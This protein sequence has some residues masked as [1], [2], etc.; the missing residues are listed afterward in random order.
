MGFSTTTTTPPTLDLAL[1]FKVVD[2]DG[3]YTAVQTIDI[4]YGLPAPLV[5]LVGINSFET[6]GLP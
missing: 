6:V 1:G 4:E 2:A 5:E 3:D